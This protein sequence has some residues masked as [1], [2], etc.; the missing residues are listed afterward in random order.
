MIK[1]LLLGFRNKCQTCVWNKE[2]ENNANC[3]LCLIGALASIKAE[4]LEKL[5]KP[6]QVRYEDEVFNDCLAQVKRIIDE[7]CK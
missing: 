5:P 2:I 4:L 6:R 1:N 3:E 7:V